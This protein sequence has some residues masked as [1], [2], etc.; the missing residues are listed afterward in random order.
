MLAFSL[1]AKTELQLRP[2]Y[3]GHIRL[4]LIQELDAEGIGLE[5][6]QRDSE[7][8]GCLQTSVRYFMWTGV[9][10]DVLF[11]HCME[12]KSGNVRSSNQGVCRSS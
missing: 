9:P 2:D 1:A 5:I 7:Q 10:E 12:A 4:F 11:C 6:A 3:G 8:A